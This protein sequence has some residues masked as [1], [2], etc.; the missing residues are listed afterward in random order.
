MRSSC[1]DKGSCR[2]RRKAPTVALSTRLAESLGEERPSWGT[3]SGATHF[4][5]RPSAVRVGKLRMID[6]A[7]LAPPPSGCLAFGKRSSSWRRLGG[8]VR[9]GLLLNDVIE[10]WIDRS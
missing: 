7:F 8:A 2:R 1:V 4:T 5:S 3:T 6:G 10:M 9:L